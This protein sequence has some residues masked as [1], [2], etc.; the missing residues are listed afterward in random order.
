MTSPLTTGLVPHEA[1]GAEVSRREFQSR[2]AGVGNLNGKKM[3]E[4]D[5]EKK[6]REACEGFESIFIQKMWQEMRNTLP[7]TNMLQGR[8]EQYWQS[9]YDQELAKSMTAAGGIGLAD[10]MYSQLSRN[11]VSASRG[12]ASAKSGSTSGFVPQVA[13][14]LPQDGEAASQAEGQDGSQGRAGH[15][16]MRGR[17]PI[18]SVYDGIAPVQDM[19]ESMQIQVLPAGTGSA[20]AALA[21]AGQPASQ[22]PL[23]V[24]P[25]EV[26]QALAALRARKE[27]AAKQEEQRVPNMNTGLNMARA[28]QFE[29][30]SKL[31]AHAVLPRTHLSEPA[32]NAAAGNG[33]TG[34]MT[35]ARQAQQAAQALDMQMRMA[36]SM[37]T[38]AAIQAAMQTGQPGP[39]GPLAEMAPG[40][41]HGQTFA[42]TSGQAS[43][44]T[45]GQAGAQA[46]MQGAMQAGI[47]VPRPQQ[48]SQPAGG[49][50]TPGP[51]MAAGQAAGQEAGQEAAQEP[52]IQKV[53]YT[54]NVPPGQ[55]KTSAND[56]LHSL[57]A[58]NATG[59]QQGQH[60]V[61]Q[62]GPQQAGQPAAAGHE[63]AQQPQLQK[64][65]YTTNV[66]PGQRKTS[67]SDILRN[68]SV[69]A[70]GP[71]SRAGAGLAAYHAQQAG[72]P[73]QA[74]PGQPQAPATIQPLQ[75]PTQNQA[76]QPA[77]VLVGQSAAGESV[78]PVTPQAGQ[79]PHLAQ[80]TGGY[81]IPPLT[82]MD[83]RR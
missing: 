36:Q 17:V 14:V 72:Q 35:Q 74:A 4:A 54:T 26:E 82:A 24:A 69:D 32:R 58:E 11:L 79:A 16:A 12:T 47:P 9:M 29:A 23:V 20:Q 50:I 66:P 5:K 46:G 57:A 67:A 18:P 6:L 68:S 15:T 21:T 49:V 55:R 34:Q 13:S 80:P 33:Q 75:A 19:G 59:P 45:G 2:L 60:P 73:L 51:A 53:R 65:R 83:L 28:A 27:A 8:E 30:G 43:G 76:G 1:S 31:G 78:M 44:F 40:Q 52:H 56:I 62:H 25:P 70:V 77:P 7:K 22:P 42:Q 61:Q 3:T 39:I 63:A 37:G 48:A 81:G 10:M 64:V 71:N 41:E 38:P